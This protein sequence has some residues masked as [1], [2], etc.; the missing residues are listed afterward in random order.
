[1]RRYLPVVVAGVLLALSAGAAFASGGAVNGGAV[2]TCVNPQGVMFVVEHPE[3]CVRNFEPVSLAAYPAG[4][5]GGGG[6]QGYYVASV[7]YFEDTAIDSPLDPPPEGAITY[8]E[9]GS[10]I[11]HHVEFSH[12]FEAGELELRCDAGDAAVDA[13]LWRSSRSADILVGTRLS[14]NPLDPFPYGFDERIK[15]IVEAGVPVGFENVGAISY[16]W[17]WSYEDGYD[18]MYFQETKFRFE[19]V[20]ADMTP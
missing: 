1:M 15:R 3:D 11:Y 20:C 19:V 5:G 10:T 16:G 9:P 8:T 7:E 14:D 13:N 4:G 6:V 12:R 18:W 2:H 17:W